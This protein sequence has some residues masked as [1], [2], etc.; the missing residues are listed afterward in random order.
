M[1]I[2]LLNVPSETPVA[3]PAAPAGEETFKVPETPAN[4]SRTPRSNSVAS[5][6]DSKPAPNGPTDPAQEEPQSYEI[7]PTHEP[8]TC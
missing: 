3:K 7:P 8:I 1:M 2:P 6:N 5:S 4:A